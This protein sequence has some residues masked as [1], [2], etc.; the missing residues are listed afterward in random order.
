LETNVAV[1]GY[2]GSKSAALEVDFPPLLVAGG[3]GAV[4]RLLDLTV[5]LVHSSVPQ[6][7]L[8][9]A[10]ACYTPSAYSRL[11]LVLTPRGNLT[12]WFLDRE[13]PLAPIDI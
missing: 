1:F 3:F 11:S 10:A 7:D 5:L 9:P 8:P 12:S 2:D 6:D 13:E 4:E